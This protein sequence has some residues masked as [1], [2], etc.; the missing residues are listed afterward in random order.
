MNKFY[1]SIVA[2]LLLTISVGWMT[3]D[4]MKLQEKLDYLES[5][6]EIREAL[7]SKLQDGH[8]ILDVNLAKVFTINTPRG[9]DQTA[10]TSIQ[11]VL[12]EQHNLVTNLATTFPPEADA[13]REAQAYIARLANVK[14]QLSQI[15][16]NDPGELMLLAPAV[17]ALN[18]QRF[19]LLASVRTAGENHYN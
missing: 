9:L 10:L 11:E 16:R 15:T 3:T 5:T 14:V 1:I 6:I 8:H 2:N 18:N 19:S 13:S 4:R 17:D 12:L 7:V